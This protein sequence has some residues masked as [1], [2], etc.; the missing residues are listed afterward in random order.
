MFAVFTA[1]CSYVNTVSEQVQGCGCALYI[2]AGKL[3]CD[4]LVRNQQRLDA[5]S[6]GCLSM[7]DSSPMRCSG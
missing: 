1:S 7:N 3:T 2:E 5:G 4:W 6:H